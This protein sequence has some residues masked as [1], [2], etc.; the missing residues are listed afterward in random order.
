MK[1]LLSLIGLTL[2]LC[3]SAQECT[4]DNDTVPA[5]LTLHPGVF[6]DG[7]FDRVMNTQ[8]FW[9]LADAGSLT[10]TLA[11]PAT[12]I[13][14]SVS[15][16]VDDMSGLYVAPTVSIPGASLTGSV[17][18]RYATWVFGHWETVTQTWTCPAGATITAGVGS[19]RTGFLLDAIAV[20]STVL[21]APSSA[22]A[23]KAPEP[24][25]D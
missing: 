7:W 12:A 23:M 2:A 4:F 25:Y 15:Y 22:P 21:D 9:D 6:S 16:Y 13:T 19:A 18:V 5:W 20:S 3:A 11:S 24:L 1:R 14:V 8:G 10:V 17:I